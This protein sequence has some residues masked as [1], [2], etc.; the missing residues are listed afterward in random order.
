[1]YIWTHLVSMYKIR[2]VH[3]IYDKLQIQKMKM[4]FHQLFDLFVFYSWSKLIIESKQKKEKA[5]DR[6]KKEAERLAKRES[7]GAQSS[8]KRARPQAGTNEQVSGV[9]GAAAA[10]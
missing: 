5:A 10:T 4:Q 9:A 1:M 3:F 6:A 7:G 8:R 2:F